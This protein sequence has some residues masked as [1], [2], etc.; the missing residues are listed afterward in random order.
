MSEK[1]VPQNGTKDFREYVGIRVA[2]QILGMNRQYVRKLF[3]SGKFPSST[4]DSAGKWLA[5]RTEVEAYKT[6]RNQPAPDGM[7]TV[8][9]ISTVTGYNEQY[10]RKL[11]KTGKWKARKVA[12][13]WYA[14]KSE[15][16]PRKKEEIP[17]NHISVSEFAEQLGYNLHYARKLCSEQKLKSRK[18]SGGWFVHTSELKRVRQ[19]YQT[20][21]AERKLTAPTTK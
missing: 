14:P 15:V 6:T 5:K 13:K 19:T 10:V 1:K 9:E 3:V 21:E 20:T 11:C 12:G 7:L 16:K 2:S 17:A 8:S 4:R 18:V